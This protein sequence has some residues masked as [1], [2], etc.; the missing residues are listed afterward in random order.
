MASPRGVIL[1]IH[2]FDLG[3]FKHRR[4]PLTITHGYGCMSLDFRPRPLNAQLTEKR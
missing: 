1:F 2:T 3:C 4:Q